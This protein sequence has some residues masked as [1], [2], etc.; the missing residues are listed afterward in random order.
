MIAQVLLFV[1]WSILA[2]FLA[3]LIEVVGVG[4]R[5]NIV[6]GAVLPDTLPTDE[7]APKNNLVRLKTKQTWCTESGEV[8][9]AKGTQRV[10]GDLPAFQA[11]S[12]REDSNGFPRD[13]SVDESR[14]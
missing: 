1:Y 9:A 7:S 10:A 8:T 11:R 4:L 12:D 3:V 2:P 13:A 6:R 5:H 14:A